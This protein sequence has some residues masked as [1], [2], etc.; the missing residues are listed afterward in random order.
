MPV[1]KPFQ[2]VRPAQNPEKIASLPYDVISEQEAREEY[3]KNPLTFFRIGRTEILLK[4]L[5][6]QQHEKGDPA[7]FE[8]GDERDCFTLPRWVLQPDR[9]GPGFL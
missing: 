4:A 1:V 5:I 3:A 9:L 7:G 6:L 8:T 2:A